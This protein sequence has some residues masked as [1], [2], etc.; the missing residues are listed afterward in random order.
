MTTSDHTARSCWL[1]QQ[2]DVFVLPSLAEAFGIATV[3]AMGC[4]LPVVVSDAG[5]TAD[6]VDPGVNG[7][8]T[9]RGDGR[10]LGVGARDAAGR[11]RPTIVDGTP[12]L[13]A[14]PR[15]ASVST[16]PPG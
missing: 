10:E 4:G 14:S 7:Y 8:I 3:E 16:R 15:S 6:I 2:A 9:K 5:G 12:G 11:R 13:G 1:Y